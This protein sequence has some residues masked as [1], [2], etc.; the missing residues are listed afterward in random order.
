MLAEPHQPRAIRINAHFLTHGS[1]RLP[2]GR[3]RQFWKRPAVRR[4]SQRSGHGTDSTVVLPL[5]SSRRTMP[6]TPTWPGPRSRRVG[7]AARAE[8]PPV[9]A[10]AVRRSLASHFL[11][12]RPEPLALAL[13]LLR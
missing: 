6:P 1:E 3:F 9:A 13:C 5:D 4:G 11:L 10:S 7:I 12:L 2:G 8:K